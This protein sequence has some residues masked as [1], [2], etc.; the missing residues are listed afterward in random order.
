[1]KTQ[2]SLRLTRRAKPNRH[3]WAPGEEPH[4]EVL[5]VSHEKW[6]GF[7]NI[8]F[9]MSPR[10]WREMRRR[11]RNEAAEQRRLRAFERDH[12]K[13]YAALYGIPTS[14]ILDGI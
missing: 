8:T 11:E 9:H 10:G 4:C 3:D 12:P 5:H 2:T 14:W 1:M 6:H 7:P 13:L